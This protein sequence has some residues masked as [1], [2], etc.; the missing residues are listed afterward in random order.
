MKTTLIL[1]IVLL[2]GGFNSFD[3]IN[4]GYSDTRANL[5]WDETTHDFGEIEKDKPVT[6]V[7]EFENKGDIPIVITSVKASCGCTATKY[8]KKPV[9]AGET[10]T[11]NVTY[12]ARKAGQFRKNVKVMVQGVSESYMLVVK[13]TVK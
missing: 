13:G 11:V 3:S 10:G 6:A 5:S 9:P 1:F 8:T 12:N 2:I 7:F 4:G